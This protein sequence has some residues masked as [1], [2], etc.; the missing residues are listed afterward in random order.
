MSLFAIYYFTTLYYLIKCWSVLGT[1][2]NNISVTKKCS[3]SF[4][5]FE[6]WPLT[7]GAK[8]S[9]AVWH[10]LP[11]SCEGVNSVKELMMMTVVVIPSQVQCCP[12]MPWY[13]LRLVGGRTQLVL[14]WGCVNNNKTIPSSI[15]ILS[16]QQY[17]LE[18]YHFPQ[19]TLPLSLIHKLNK[20]HLGT[21][22]DGVSI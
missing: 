16:S 4:S 17:F 3:N 22:A 19:L 2:L 9:L 1:E 20:E 11:I 21:G 10:L 7:G 15:N 8:G 6:I 18:I 13:L 12:T 5:Y 14:C